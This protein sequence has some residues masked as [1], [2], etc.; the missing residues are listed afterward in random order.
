MRIAF[1]SFYSGKI[2]RGVEVATQVLASKLSKNYETTLFQ[3][4]DRVNSEINT[5][6]FKIE[7]KWPQD[8]SKSCLRKFYLDHY[9]RKI[10]LFSLKFLP[11]FVKYKYDVVIPTNGGW[12]VL[13]LR[14]ITWIY[15]KKMIVQGNAGIGRDDYWQLLLKPD[16]F[17]AISPQ[18]YLWAKKKAPKVNSI[19]IPYGVDSDLFQKTLPIQIPLKKPIILCVSALL[20]YKRVELLIKAVEKISNASLL[21]IGHGPL[22]KQIQ[23]LGNKLLGD[24]FLL[25]TNINHNEL[26]RYYKGADIFSLP[27]KSSEAFG[28]VYVEAMAAGLSVV[29]PDDLNRREIIADAGILVDPENTT[30]YAEALKK[31]LSLNL[32]DNCLKQARKFDWDIIIE[33]YKRIL[34][35]I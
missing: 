4:G 30:A 25:K 5:Q 3:A 7:D 28:I 21:I 6:I 20:E 33:S 23:E 27:S 32:H 14:I 1:L 10:F 31:C 29:A 35:N 24:R 9:S 18:G 13:L 12:Q 26:I 19:Y 8:S 2:D 16:I 17:V 15:G 34:S 11:F 22:E